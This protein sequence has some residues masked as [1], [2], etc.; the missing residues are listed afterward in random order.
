M[1][2][3]LAVLHLGRNRIRWVE[4]ARLG[5]LLKTCAT[6][7]CSTTSWG[8]RGCQPGRC[9]LSEALHAAPLRQQ[10]GPSAPG[11]ARRLQALVLPHNRV[12]RWRP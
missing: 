5:G 6:Y 1:P 12:A 7:Y 8:P 9:G 10:A 3:T 4:A 11:A 2:R